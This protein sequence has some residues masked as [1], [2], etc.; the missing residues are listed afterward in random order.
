MSD[1]FEKD[2]NELE[3][4]TVSADD[5]VS[6]TQEIPDGESTV[7]SAP[8]EHKVKAPKKS[9]KKRLTSIIAA[10]VAVAVLVGGTIAVIKLIP[11]MTEEEAP[12]SVFEDIAVVDADSEAFKTVTI[13]NGNG[14]F[15]F[16]TQQITATNEAGETETTDYWAV[17]GIDISKLSNTTMNN[18]IASAASV[19]ATREI[20]TKTASEC[21]FDN[22]KIK[23][24]VTSDATDPYTVL[25]GDVSP[26]GLGSYMMLEGGDK[27]YVAADSEFSDFDF[28]LLDLADQ[29]SIPTTTFTSDTSDNKSEDGAYAYF[30][31]LTL[32]GK[33]F[34]E[35][36]TI[37]NNTAE[38]DSAALVP[39]LITTPSQRL[40]NA[41]NLTSLIGIF[42][43]E[44]P[45]AGCYAF[46]IT[47][48]TL[49]DFGLDNPDAVVT[50]T[51][52]GEARSFKV[53]VVND[54][55]CAVVYDG[56]KMIRKVLTS[57]FGFLS[58]TTQDL[59]YKN[60][61][62]NSINDITSLKLND[63]EGEVKF[64]I[65]YEENEDS[66]KTYHI[67][68]DG[69]E[70]VTKNFQ[71]FYADFV[72]IQCSDFTT[73]DISTEPDGTITFTFYDGSETVI[74]FYKA[75]DTQYQ[76]RIDGID[77]GKIT[78]SAFNK[79][80]KNIRGVAAGEQPV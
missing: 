18:I 35:T 24:A 50:M 54:D 47:D 7:F 11:E 65:S 8:A 61:F 36:V 9:S 78:S 14:E 75:N 70:I 3:E 15:K 56:A 31:S 21:G 68:V 12:S 76:Y 25:I 63:S 34:P 5:T 60:L 40:A 6:E 48:Q 72:G 2:K 64:D 46:D 4:Q 73:K 49:K 71:D 51:I 33:L 43:S 32:S 13:T 74:E 52:D 66:V 16:V 19:T 67:S 79:M 44:I 17:E 29:T 45:V 57:N 62:M 41:D 38:T 1:F 53:S 23:V 42:S 69:E 22:P 28:A 80:I 10:C 58:L 59:Y 27:I 55:Y 20:D 30:D 37:I 26:D 39:Y 77:M